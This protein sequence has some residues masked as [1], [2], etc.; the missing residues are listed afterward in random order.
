MT[1]AK[2]DSTE[3]IEL[4]L[5]LGF[6]PNNP[7]G[8]PRTSGWRSRRK[9]KVDEDIKEDINSSQQ[10]IDALFRTKKTRHGMS[11]SPD[12]MNKASDEV[13]HL[14]A[15]KLWE[16]NTNKNNS[17]PEPSTEKSSLWRVSSHLLE[18]VRDWPRCSSARFE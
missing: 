6:R 8:G 16:R 1:K 12:Y 18:H 7:E 9:M 13:P 3:V 17:L 14:E 15:R 11:S 10:S 4:A 2:F 5:S